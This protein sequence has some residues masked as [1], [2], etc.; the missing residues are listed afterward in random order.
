MSDANWTPGREPRSVAASFLSYP[1]D[2]CRCSDVCCLYRTGG[3]H[4]ATTIM[5]LTKNA[6]VWLFYTRLG[7]ARVFEQQLLN[8]TT[9]DLEFKHQGHRSK[10][11][12]TWRKMVFL[13]LWIH[14]LRGVTLKLV[15]K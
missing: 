13:L 11:A 5:L 4:H 7:R 2:Y 6:W 14:V 15:S 12:V 8:E 10:V 9:F 1:P 3:D